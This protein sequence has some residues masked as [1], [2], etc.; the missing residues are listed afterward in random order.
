MLQKYMRMLHN[1]HVASV[2]FKCFRCFIRML[3]MH[4][5]DVAKVDLNVAYICNGFQV[6]SGVL[7][8]TY[9]A[10][11]SSKYRKS[12]S[13]VALVAMEPSFDSHLL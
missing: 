13:D 4:H 2:C 6:F 9:V 8:R 1:M 12:R 3:Q 11:V 7:F 10:S 5:L